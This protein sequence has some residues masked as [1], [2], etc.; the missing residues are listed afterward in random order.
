MT[1]PIVILPSYYA[2][3]V[4]AS[5]KNYGI[6]DMRVDGKAGVFVVDGF[7]RGQNGG[8]VHGGSK[9]VESHYLALASRERRAL[10]YRAEPELHALG[11]DI[12][13]RSAAMS[14]EDFRA[15]LQDEWIGLNHGGL[16]LAVTYANFDGGGRDWRAW[17][18]SEDAGSAELADIQLVDED[19]PLLAPLAGHWPL[20]DLADS[21]VVV[22]GTGSIGS[23][24]T[25]ALAS[26]GIRRM[27]LVDPDRLLMHNFSRH[28]AHSD[29]LGRF[30]V[31]AERERLHQ[32][33]PGIE[34]DALPLDVIYDADVMRPLFEHADIVLC[35]ADGIDSRRTV[36]HL[37]RRAGTAAVFACVL[38]N[39]AFGEILRIASPTVGCLLCARAHLQARGGMRPEHTLDRGY[40]M[41]SRYLPMTA[42]GGDLGLV[43]QLAGKVVVATLLDRKG[44]RDQRLAGD[45]AILALR[46]VPGMAEPFNLTAAGELAWE[47]L[48]APRADCPTCG[49]LT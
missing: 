19:R 13:R 37:A 47:Q 7:T 24:A 34:V 44:H 42:V 18:L 14:L 6:L 25:D 1:R 3:R 17:I 5:A 2:D 8:G 26:Y 9:W 38:E 35:A 27:T 10:W 43:G 20:A 32:R 31:V 41:G 4:A 23:H 40:G 15:C 21:H 33:D 22:V 11:F 28:R 30:K 48:P 46:S 29:Q 36:S 16:T 45:H 49:T 12:V 39:G